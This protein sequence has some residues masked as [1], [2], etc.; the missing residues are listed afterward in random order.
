[1]L[2]EEFDGL[3]KGLLSKVNSES[4]PKGLVLASIGLDSEDVIAF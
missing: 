1:M 3:P 4:S 2:G